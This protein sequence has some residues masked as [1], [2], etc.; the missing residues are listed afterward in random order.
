[1]REVAP[2]LSRLLTSRVEMETD[3]DGGLPPVLMD[4]GQCTQVLM[5]LLVNARD[6]MPNG[7]RVV[8]RTRSLE[9]GDPRIPPGGPAG[10]VVL[11]EVEDGGTGMTEEVK[12]RL[13]EP[14]FTT[15]EAGRGTGLGLPVVLAAVETAG[16]VLSVESE[17]GEGTTFRVFLPA[18]TT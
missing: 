10:R 17:V 11:L 14:F 18:I 8:V 15:K 7:G 5:N 16:G 2:M 13:F 9:P 4:P 3:L 1:V 6:A 12:R